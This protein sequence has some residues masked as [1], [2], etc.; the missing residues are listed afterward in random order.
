MGNPLQAALARILAGARQGAMAGIGG[1]PPMGGQGRSPL[2]TQ[3]QEPAPTTG[4]AP[5]PTPNVQTPQGPVSTTA[6]P[7]YDVPKPQPPGAAP[8]ANAPV[9]QPHE[10]INSLAQLI[11]G[12]KHRDYTK[13]AAEMQN[14]WTDLMEAMD[15]LRDPAQAKQAKVMI[16][17]IME[18]HGKDLAKFFKG[19]FE[20]VKKQQT[21]AGAQK[22]PD[23]T[24]Q[25]LEGALQAKQ[26]EAAQPPSAGGYY[27]PMAGP[28]AQLRNAAVNANLSAA[29]SDPQR[30]L[31]SQ[32][33]SGEMRQQELG[34]AGLAVTPK[35]DVELKKAALEVTKFQ[36]EAQKAAA[37][38]LAAQQ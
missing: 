25:G 24:E 11:L 16:D 18:R 29:R 31:Q 32:L 22:E 1:M 38:Y 23:P 13:K 17:T 4:Q 8:T 6:P 5:G 37:E 15:A 21:Q 19:R 27:L 14:V 3:G 7:A 36:H 12:W 30:L 2:L 35:M 28:E 33:T 20:E 10:Q 9:P 34:A 26:K